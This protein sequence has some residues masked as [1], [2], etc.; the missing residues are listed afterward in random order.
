MIVKRQVTFLVNSI[1]KPDQFKCWFGHSCLKVA[2]IMVSYEKLLLGEPCDLCLVVGDVTP[3]AAC[4]ITAQKL[5]IP[6]AHVEAGIRSG[7]WS[8]PEE[9]NRILTDLITNYF[10]LPVNMNTI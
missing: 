8:M 4:A 1:P 5:R 7:D 9:I 10:L 2:S 3:T 6:V